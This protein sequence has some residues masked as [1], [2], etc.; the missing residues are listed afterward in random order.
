[1]VS[2]RVAGAWVCAKP[3]E[4]AEYWWMFI[5]FISIFWQQLQIV[6]YATQ[7]GDFP[8]LNWTSARDMRSIELWLIEV[9]TSVVDTSWL[10]AATLKVSHSET[11]PLGEENVSGFHRKTQHELT[12]RAV[13]HGWNGKNRYSNRTEMSLKWRT[14]GIARGDDSSCKV[15][16]TKFCKISKFFKTFLQNEFKIAA[17]I[18][19]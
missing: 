4:A 17:Q 9:K 8:S 10:C 14:L 3:M 11:L 6:V 18:L 5:K 2:R 15:N 13:W 7:T 1:M 19:V 16:F 12:E